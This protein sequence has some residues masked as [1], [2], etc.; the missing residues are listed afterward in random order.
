MDTFDRSSDAR[1][2]LPRVYCICS[3]QGGAVVPTV[4][5]IDAETDEEAVGVARR[6]NLAATRE[7]W[8]HHRLVARIPALRA[9]SEAPRSSLVSE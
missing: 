5:L 1:R 3:F 2:Q 9:Q 8:D 7:L 6:R 4:E